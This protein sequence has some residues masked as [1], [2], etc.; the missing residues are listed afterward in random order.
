MEAG[1]GEPGPQARAWCWTFGRCDF[2]E[3]RWELRVAGKPV[4]LERKP[5]EVLQYLLRHAGE[6]VT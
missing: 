5:A 6:A 4:E 1:T 2:D 3:S